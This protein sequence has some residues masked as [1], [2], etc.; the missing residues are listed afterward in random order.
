MDRQDCSY[1]SLSSNEGAKTTPDKAS[2]VIGLNFLTV[3]IGLC[4]LSNKE[5]LEVSR[6]NEGLPMNKQYNFQ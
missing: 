6:T 2:P 4:M 1:L 3:S 5:I